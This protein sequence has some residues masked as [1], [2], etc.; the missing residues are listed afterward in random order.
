MAHARLSVAQGEASFN[1]GAVPMLREAQAERY[2]A[3]QQLSEEQLGRRHDVAK[4]HE[5]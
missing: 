2:L 1:D 3:M 5:E 4:M